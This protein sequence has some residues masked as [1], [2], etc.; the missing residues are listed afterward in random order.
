MRLGPRPS[1]KTLDSGGDPS[2]ATCPMQ[3]KTMLQKH[4]VGVTW[5]HSG[6]KVVGAG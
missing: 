2:P 5:C 6:V 1:L 3:L 4:F